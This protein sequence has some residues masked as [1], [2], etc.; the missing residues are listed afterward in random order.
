M[1][2]QLRSEGYDVGMLPLDETMLI[3]SVLNQT[4]AKFN[5]ADLN[6]AYRMKVRAGGDTEWEGGGVYCLPDV[7]VLPCVSGGQ[8]LA[9]LAVRSF[10]HDCRERCNR[11]VQASPAAP[12]P[13]SLQVDEYEKLC[14]YS[15]ALEENWG[16]PP[17]N[18]NSNGQELLIY[19]KQF[20]NVFIG[21]QPTFGYEG[22][23]MR[24]LFR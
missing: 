9:V 4:D 23:P 6:I 11:R 19:G 10:L 13:P 14:E 2:K 15:E 22:D 24:L 1:L 8:N 12:L 3:K 17:G 7:S 20:G 5:S 21:V 18:L 16:K